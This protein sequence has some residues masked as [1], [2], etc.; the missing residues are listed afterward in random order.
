MIEDHKMRN[1]ITA[2]EAR[3]LSEIDLNAECFEAIIAWL[4]DRIVNSAKCKKTEIR[5][6]ENKIDDFEFLYTN[7]MYL[8]K[9]NAFKVLYPKIKEHYIAN[10]FKVD[11]RCDEHMYMPDT[12][13]ISWS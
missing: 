9:N 1:N 8:F 4:N 11:Y 6:H 13:I 12:L 2:D 3:T 5:V 7:S 10:G